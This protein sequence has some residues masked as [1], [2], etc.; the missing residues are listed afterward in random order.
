MG[1]WSPQMPGDGD[2]VLI[3]RPEASVTVSHESGSDTI[4]NLTCNEMLVISGGTLSVSNALQ[5]DGGCSLSGG[6]LGEPG[7]FKSPER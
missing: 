7:P 2:N 3:D 5:I 1:N 6:I 4:K